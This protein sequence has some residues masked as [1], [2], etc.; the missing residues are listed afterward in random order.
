[1]QKQSIPFNIDLLIPDKNLTERFRAVK[2]LDTFD[3]SGKNFHPEG[4]Y[5]VETFGIVGTPARDARYG[6]IDLKIGV[7]HPVIFKTITSLKTFYK[8]ILS[9]REFAIWNDETKDFIKSNSIEGQTGYQF[10]IEHYKDIIFEERASLKREQSIALLNKYKDNGLI[11][12]ML[13]IPA[14]YRDLEIDENGRQSSDEINE[15]YYKLLA[16]SNTINSS[17]VN[18]SPEAYNTQRMTL[19]NTVIEIYDY[20]S[21]I[22]DGK[23]NLMMGKWASRKVFNGTRNVITSSDT[24]V[25]DL[26][27][28]NKLTINDT[29][30]GLYQLLKAMLPVSIYHLKN[31][32]LSSV[33][34]SAGVAAFLTNKKTLQSERVELSNQE[35]EKWLTN[36]GLEKLI[37]YYKENSIRHNPIDVE[38]YYLGLVYKG[39]D[40][41]FKLIHGIDELPDDRKK[42]DCYP[43]TFTDLFY[44]SIYDIANS[45]PVLV[46]RYPITGVGSVYPSKVFLKTTIDSEVRT[47]LGNDWKPLGGDKIAKQFPVLNS[48]FFNSMSP[49][50]SRLAG[51]GGDFDGDMCSATVLYS[52]EAIKEVNNFLNSK[53]CYVNTDGSF[54]YDTNTDT[55]KYILQTLTG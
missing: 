1:M 36:E 33:F 23:K 6:Y 10:F 9:S 21:N 39:P 41:T 16:I 43:I 28:K 7:M 3:A 19:Q 24:V 54:T 14:G 27:D 5:S 20:I 51:L 55:I 4:L 38:G 37:T 2:S 13:V 46:T 18:I 40:N 26:D 30:I 11:D 42:E 32:F 44:L 29:C 45:Y 8:D 15:L 34:S 48:A 50:P 52:D 35:Y 31:G 17:T 47:E 53:S 22:I 12:K 49:S 25:Q